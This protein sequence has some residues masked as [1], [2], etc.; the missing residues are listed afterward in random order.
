MLLRHLPACLLFCS[1]RVDANGL[2]I[3]QEAGVRA[4]TVQ[5][6]WDATTSFLSTGWDLNY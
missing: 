3:S 1:G 5:R 4:L 6:G 2:V